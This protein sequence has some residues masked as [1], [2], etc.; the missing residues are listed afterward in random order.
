MLL[1][2][3]SAA[4]WRLGLVAWCACWLTPALAW[5][6]DPPLESPELALHSGLVVAG[7]TYGGG[8]NAA[9]F[10]ALAVSGRALVQWVALEGEVLGQVPSAGNGPLGSVSGVARVG[11]SFSRFF[12]TVGV[13]ATSASQ[14]GGV[15]L[16]PSLYVATALGPVVASLGVFDRM[17]LAP[18][19]LSASWHGFGVGWVFPLGGEAFG[20]FRVSPT[21]E[22]E[23][24]FVGVS[25]FN[26]FTLSGLV[27]IVWRPS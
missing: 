1:T 21:L 14:W 19:H 16:L 18:V 12:G 11:V 9:S 26:S 27:G 24:R 2:R 7:T 13:L 17:G 6:D 4:P 8:S 15:Q 5:A 25:L 20:R 10:V 22:V 3:R 23:A